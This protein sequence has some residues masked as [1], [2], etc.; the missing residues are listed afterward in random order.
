LIFSEQIPFARKQDA[1]HSYKTQ[2]IIR[3]PFVDQIIRIALEE[4]FGNHGDVTARITP[5]DC[6]ARAEIVARED[7]IISGVSLA[8]EVFRRVD[9]SLR[10]TPN[11]DDGDVLKKGTVIASVNGW[12]RSILAGER[13][14]LNFLQRLSG[15][16]SLT[17]SFVDLCEGTRAEIL[18]TRKTTP[19]WRSLAKYAVACGGGT[20]HRMGLYDQVLIKDNHLAL[21]GGEV[22]VKEAVKLARE[23]APKGT[24]IE[25]EVTT[26]EGALAATDA[27]ADIIL[28]DNMGVEDLVKTV[29][30][31]EAR[32]KEAE[33]KKPA[34]EASGG[35]NLNTVAA[36]AKTGVDRIS[37]GALTHSSP[38]LDIALDM[39]VIPQD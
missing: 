4:D 11:V 21:I 30:A 20:N 24:P 29:L 15:I 27:G 38:A 6:R 3:D 23:R 2:Q 28:L 39:D 17:R 1:M 18:D 14:A 19:G 16:A 31:V 8:K 35:I 10:F 22:G 36:V 9:G 25:I 5:E 12:A 7:G 13:I 32:V 34:L 26:L 33:L 37:V